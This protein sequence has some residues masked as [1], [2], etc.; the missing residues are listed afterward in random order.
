MVEPMNWIYTAEA[1][2]AHI[3]HMERKMEEQKKQYEAAYRSV[4]ADCQR[5]LSQRHK[6][7]E[8]E[9]RKLQALVHK[10]EVLAK[11]QESMLVYLKRSVSQETRVNAGVPP[12]GSPPPYVP[13]RPGLNTPPPPAA[14]PPAPPLPPKSKK[15]PPPPPPRPGA[16]NARNALIRELQLSSKFKA[17]QERYN[18]S[19]RRYERNK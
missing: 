9:I 4:V 13:P 6:K 17:A 14:A 18:N 16:R 11:R 3:E 2:L 12:R 7:H 5:E 1:R 8:E 15:A 19:N 10:Y